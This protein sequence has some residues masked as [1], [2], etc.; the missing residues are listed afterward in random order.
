MDIHSP[1]AK[2]IFFLLGIYILALCSAN[3]L[4][5]KVTSLFGISVSVGIFALPFTFVVTDIIEDVFGKKVSRQFLLTGLACLVLLFILTGLS[6]AL[7][8]AER[9]ADQADAYNATFKNS[10]RFILASIVA[11]GISQSH[12]IW[13]FEFWKKK[14]SGKMLWL[15]NNLSTM[16]SQ[17]IDTLLFMFIAF[18]QLTDKFTVAYILEL[19]VVYWLFKIAFAALDTPLVYAGVKWLKRE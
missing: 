7:P 10:M 8:A 19:A 13:A 12:D 2:K 11:F 6:V 14:T 1:Q 9:F 5:S 17:A 18:Y 15:R 3:L 4:G 16:A